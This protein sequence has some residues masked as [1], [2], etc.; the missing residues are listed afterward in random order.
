MAPHYHRAKKEKTHY[1]LNRVHVLGPNSSDV[2]SIYHIPLKDQIS[3]TRIQ[4]HPRC[5]AL[6][7]TFFH[8]GYFLLFGAQ[9][10]TV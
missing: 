5:S 7:P 4:T 6:S 1:V 2:L 8:L 9:G 10:L 3:G